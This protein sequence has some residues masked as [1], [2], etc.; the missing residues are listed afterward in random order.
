MKKRM[1]ISLLLVAV[2]VLTTVPAHAEAMPTIEDKILESYR[3]DIQVDV[4]ECHVT[5]AQLKSAHTELFEAGLLPW[6]AS[7]R[8]EYEYDTQTYQVLNFSPI[9][10]DKEAYDRTAYELRVA[11][12]L[13][14]VVQDGMT[15]GQICL[16]LYDALAVQY[17][18]DENY[19]LNTGYDLLTGGTS[20][21]NGYAEA[22]KELLTRVGIPCEIVTSE[23]MDHTWN[24]VCLGGN[25]YHVDVTWADPVP[26]IYGYVSHAYFLLT[27][28][29]ISSGDDPHYGWVTERTCTDE[30][31]V[32]A[33][34]KSID[35]QIC[36]SDNTTSY[37]IREKDWTNYITA[38]DVKTGEE[39]VLHTVE[40]EYV[41]IGAGR[42]GYSHGGLSLWNDR[43][44]FSGVDT[45]YS[46]NP[47]G[48]D[49]VKEF[50]YDA[51]GNGK[52]IYGCRVANDTIY[53]TLRTHDDVY[54]AMEVPLEDSGY[55]KHSYTQEQIVPTCEAGGV[56]V[57][58]CSCGLRVETDPVPPVEHDYVVEHEKKASFFSSG[59]CTRIC[60]SCGNVDVEILPQIV[61]GDWLKEKGYRRPLLI[62]LLLGVVIVLS[63]LGK[64]K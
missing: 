57:H 5:E 14:Y 27:D 48:S 33:Y 15:Q 52:H 56:T 49:V 1:I 43:L 55:H 4:S 63:R 2:M 21:C 32:N 18:Y 3:Y 61:F 31:F 22:Y 54:S 40:V 11:E 51:S 38:R 25:W 12:I 17:H 34:W 50:V 47:D 20:M 64:K 9:C 6:Y 41:D 53:L 10:L 39:T 60:D 58:T 30:S 8:Y 26:D 13:D 44:W 7:G 42:Y 24:L 28:E 19:T 46:M 37:H 35:S 16:A 23:E 45:V 29:E 36:Y 62:A 59:V